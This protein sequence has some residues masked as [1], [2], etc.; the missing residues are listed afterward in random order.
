LC[1]PISERRSGSSRNAA[2][3]RLQ[4][5]FELSP[6]PLA[7]SAWRRSS[8][9][10]SKLAALPSSTYPPN[11]RGA[12]QPD[13]VKTADCTLS[14]YHG[15]RTPAALPS[16]HSNVLEAWPRRFHSFPP[17]RLA[18]RLKPRIKTAT[19]YFSECRSKPAPA[20]L[21]LATA[22]PGQVDSDAVVE[23]SVE[24]GSRS[25]STYR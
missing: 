10:P 17:D 25:L 19:R 6:Q 7:K 21:R 4:P 5:L 3:N 18:A 13:S 23:V 14:T 24:A 11:P 22:T 2:R 8:K 20:P 15:N 1:S 16:G 9:C 12:S